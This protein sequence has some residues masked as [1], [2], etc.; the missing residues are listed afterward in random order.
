MGMT[1][2]DYILL[3]KAFARTMPVWLPGDPRG[4]YEAKYEQWEVDVK[5]MCNELEAQNPNFDRT[6]FQYNATAR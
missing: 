4:S 1:R 3:A 6:L 2:S 5:S